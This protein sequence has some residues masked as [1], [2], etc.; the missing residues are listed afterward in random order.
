MPETPLTTACREIADEFI[1]FEQL[2]ANPQVNK[3]MIRHDSAT[4]SQLSQELTAQG[5]PN[6]LI[7]DANR[8]AQACGDAGELFGNMGNVL[9]AEAEVPGWIIGGC[10]WLAAVPPPNQP[11]VNTLPATMPTGPADTPLN[12]NGIS[13]SDPDSANLTVVLDAAPDVTELNVLN[14]GGVTGNDTTQVTITGTVAMCNTALGLVRVTP[15]AAYVGQT[16]FQI[17]TDDGAGGTDTDPVIV[18]FT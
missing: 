12:V 17:T 14:V 10:D 4:L 18:E 9:R 1:H 16:G 13:V 11:P 3:K 5:A 7:N 6:N 8:A 15:A 2:H